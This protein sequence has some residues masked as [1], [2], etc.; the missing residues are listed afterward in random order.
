MIAR[1]TALSNHI[2]AFCRFLRKK[3]FLLGPSEQA[4][5]LSAIELLQPYDYRK[6]LQI[7]LK[8][9]LAK[10]QEDVLL[11]DGLYEEYWKELDRAVNSKLKDKEDDQ[12][13][14]GPQS[15]PPSIE[16][17]KSWLYGNSPE[18]TAEMASYS[19]LET[20]STKDFSAFNEAEMREVIQL[21]HLIARSL[22]NKLNRRHK[23]AR[24]GTFDLRRTLR[25][26]LRRGGEIIDL[27]FKKP[28]LRELQLILI[29]DVSKSMDLYSQ[30]LIQ[31]IY[32][33]QNAYRH[34][35]TF[36]FSTT[37]HRI[38]AQLK[39]KQFA[40]AMEELSDTV[41][42]WSGGTKI[43]ASLQCFWEDYSGRLLNSNTVV[44]IM[45]DGWDTGEVPLL[46]KYMQ[47][48]QRK[49][50]RVIWLNPLA[51][52]PGFEPNVK[53]MAA[54]LPFIDVFAPGHNVESLRKVVKQ[55]RVG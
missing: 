41:P 11:F 30:F 3:G 52:N 45:S 22:A 43:G 13:G 44:L 46:E 17:I 5:A 12:P 29:C 6:D 35:E 9:V 23:A 47:K 38:T 19:S 54:A 32:A 55:W 18:E 1:H 42:D 7:A 15:R 25:G 27:A 21:I 24:I 49:A 37:L 48:I 2:V 36:V 51:G 40:R 16:A 33:F 10:K 8:A 50:A 4:D 31:F 34:I 53:G 20:L 39:H 14:P 28:Q 26:N